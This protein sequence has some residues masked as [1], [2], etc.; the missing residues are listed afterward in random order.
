MLRKAKDLLRRVGFNEGSVRFRVA[1]IVTLL[2]NTAVSVGSWR[3]SEK[4]LNPT[5]GAKTRPL[6]INLRWQAESGTP[7]GGVFVTDEEPRPGES[8]LPRELVRSTTVTPSSPAGSSPYTAT[9]S[10]R[11][12]NATSGAQDTPR[13]F[14]RAAASTGRTGETDDRRPKSSSGPRPSEPKA[15]FPALAATPG[16][17]SSSV[18]LNPTF[19][20]LTSDQA[21]EPNLFEPSLEFWGDPGPE[22]GTTAPPGLYDAAYFPEGLL[23]FGTSFYRSSQDYF[24][25]DWPVDSWS[26]FFNQ[27]GEGPGESG[28]PSPAPP[29]PPS[30]PRENATT[31]ASPSK[32]SG[33]PD[34]SP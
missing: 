30:V 27:V 34:G 12:T 24:Y 7:G 18:N 14:V 15:A 17:F 19:N 26:S 2:Y 11:S 32:L 31:T 29:I 21:S 8:P 1:E 23:D 9:S 6:D 28:G 3:G 5:R 33:S 22:D 20:N 10:L 4:A 25:A 16:P 13:E